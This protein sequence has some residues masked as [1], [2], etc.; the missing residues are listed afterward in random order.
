MLEWY[1]QHFFVFWSRTPYDSL[2]G[3]SKL[4]YV[5][6]RTEMVKKF[7]IKNDPKQ[8]RLTELLKSAEHYPLGEHM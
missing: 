2:Q 8:G 1:S 5:P 7:P 6:L 3:L 4:F